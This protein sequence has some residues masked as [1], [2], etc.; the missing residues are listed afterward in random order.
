MRPSKFGA[1]ARSDSRPVVGSLW[2][3]PRPDRDVNRIK[4][5]PKMRMID[6]VNRPDQSFVT[7]R[8]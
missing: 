6:A 8:P 2:V 1:G 3:P 7:D 5:P 4:K